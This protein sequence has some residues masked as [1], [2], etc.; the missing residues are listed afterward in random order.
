M[1]KEKNSIIE[2]PTICLFDC[3]EEVVEEIKNDNFNVTS[4]SLGH[5]IIVSNHR[6]YDRCLCSPNLTIP[7]NLHEY[8]ICIFDLTNSTEEIY[9]ELNHVKMLETNK[10]SNYISVEYPQKICNIRPFGASL[11]KKTIIEILNKLSIII[12]FASKQVKQDYCTV[13]VSNYGHETDETFSSSNYDFLPNEVI[14]ENKSGEKIEII[15]SIKGF[16]KLFEDNKSKIHYHIT[17]FHPTHRENYKDIKNDNFIPLLFSKSGEIISYIEIYKKSRLV[18]LPDF[19]DKS[20]VLLSL[21]KVILPGYMPELFPYS[22]KFKWKEENKYWLPNHEVIMREKYSFMKKYEEDLDNIEQRISENRQRFNFLHEML[23]ETGDNLVKAIVE[24]L[25]WLGFEEVVDMDEQTQE[26]Q[27]LEE[28]IQINIDDGLLII[29]CKGIGGTSSDS[30]CSQISKI[31]H[32]RCK[33]R[34]SFDVYAL[35]IVN[36]QRHLPP[37]KRRNPPFSKQQIKDSLYDERGLVSTWQ[38]FNLYFDI[39]IGVITKKEAQKDLLT[40]GLVELRPSNLKLIGDLINVVK[41]NTVCIVK[42]GSISINVND[43]IFIEKDG[44]F[45]KAMIKEIQLKKKKVDSIKNC[46][47]GIRLDKNIKIKSKLW[48]KVIE[49]DSED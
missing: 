33:Q 38:L 17:F 32:R 13:I 44:T 46:E 45:T 30:E 4:T 20:A 3:E 18:V 2:T 28:D 49:I 43:E 19:E 21:L 34:D 24:F 7:P 40:C 31:K 12:V 37:L 8:D 26:K 29:E 42:L 16:T 35:Y 14:D 5:S 47:V 36:H 9:K 1:E 39:E 25:C 27:P 41:D 22:T 11:I 48:K 6:K 10:V 15:N 23:C